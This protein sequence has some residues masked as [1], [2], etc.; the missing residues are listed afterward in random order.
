MQ[1]GGHFVHAQAGG[2]T[3]QTQ[4]LAAAGEC[5]LV[6]VL[7]RAHGHCVRGAVVEPG[8]IVCKRER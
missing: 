6:W 4:S 1:S 2:L 3:R 5:E 7:M 8:E